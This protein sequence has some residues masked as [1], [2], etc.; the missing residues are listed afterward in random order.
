VAVLGRYTVTLKGM[1]FQVGIGTLPHEQDRP[2]RIEIDLS[3]T[4]ERLPEFPG[5]GAL[6]YREL[7]AIA[8]GVMAR[9]PHSYLEDVAMR[10]A[11]SVLTLERVAE[12]AVV[13][14]KPNAPLPGPLS[15][16]EVSVTL[17]RDA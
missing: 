9:G 2:Q 14:R 11:R 1:V 5:D 13:I 7:Y 4:L 8:S 17:G 12:V 3:A 15:Y 6:D 10:L 16:A